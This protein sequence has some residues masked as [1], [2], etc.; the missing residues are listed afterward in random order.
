MVE[1]TQLLSV[2]GLFSSILI[3]L[4]WFK[5]DTAEMIKI[6]QESTDKRL[7]STDKRLDGFDRRIEVIEKTILRM[8]EENKDFHKKLLEI[9]GRRH[10]P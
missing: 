7:E 8:E 1:L 10:T 2:L 4:R 6:F 3:I 9:E 5:T